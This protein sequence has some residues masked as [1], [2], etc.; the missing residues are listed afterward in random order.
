VAEPSLTWPQ[1]L[2]WRMKR[3][4]L[5]PI[6]TDAAAHVVSRLCG[7]QAQVASSALLAIRLRQRRSKPG[8]VSRALS[9]GTLVKTWAMRGAL[10]LLPADEAGS[11]LSLIA[12]GRSWERPVWARH[13]GVSP[14][15]M[16]RLRGAVRDALGDASLTREELVA[17]LTATRDFGHVGDWLRSGWGTLLKPLAW[18]GDICFGPNRGRNVTFIRPEV[19]S[20]KWKAL[21]EP[22]EAAPRVITTYLSVFGPATIDRFDNWLAGGGFGRRKLKAWFAS[23]GDRI[24]EVSVDGVASF[25]LAEDV[26]EIAATRP[27]STV[28]LL[29]GFDQFVL[30]PGT[31]DGHVTPAPRR[32]AVSRQSGWI[33]PVV[34]R[35]GVVSGTWELDGERVVVEWFKEAGRLP[36][37]EVASEVARL[38]EIVGRKLDLSAATIS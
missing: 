28:R 29:G 9:N 16:E 19:A 37:T 33:A 27:S 5:D 7:V 36:R 32:S 14:K 22:D 6:G 20:S 24:A 18:Q 2:S 25:V 12:S 4:L 17:A 31:A 21:R 30:G 26:D 38:G 1:A 8:D 13:F 23:L 3:Q 11:Y 10:H 35:G 15:D 34:L